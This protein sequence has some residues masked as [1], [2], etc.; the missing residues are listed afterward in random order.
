MIL[1]LI[2]SD[3]TYIILKFVSLL[4]DSLLRNVYR[5]E[6]HSFRIKVGRLEGRSDYMPLQRGAD[7]R[8][9]ALRTDP[10]TDR[11]FNG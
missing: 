1:I 5:T 9:D 2:L 6:N 7:N 4:Y 8:T 11:P 10:P 3:A